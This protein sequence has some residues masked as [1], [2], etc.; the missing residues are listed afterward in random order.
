MF[1]VALLGVWLAYRGGVPSLL[2]LGYPAVVPDSMMTSELWFPCMTSLW[3]PEERLRVFTRGENW[4]SVTLPCIQLSSI[5][6]PV[7]PQSL[8]L[9]PLL[10]SFLPCLLL[11]SFFPSFLPSFLPSYLV[12][13]FPAH[14][15]TSVLCDAKSFSR[16]CTSAE[17]ALL[18]LNTDT[19]VLLSGSS[20]F[21]QT[22]KLFFCEQL[23]QIHFYGDDEFLQTHFF[24]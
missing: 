1:L 18:T 21:Q 11:R 2:R 7:L 15:L 8:S 14:E 4:K 13:L 20:C 17:P 16:G 19:P 10:P 12:L 3:C 6:R 24:V 5:P 23:P 22:R 9:S